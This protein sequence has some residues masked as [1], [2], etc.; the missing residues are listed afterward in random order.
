MAYVR[1]C[2]IHD[3]IIEKNEK[4]NIEIVQK[5]YHDVEK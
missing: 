3:W 2:A 1:K 5:Y 4:S